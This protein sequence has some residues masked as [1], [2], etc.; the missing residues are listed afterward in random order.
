MLSTGTLKPFQ[1]DPLKGQSDAQTQLYNFLHLYFITV[2]GTTRLSSELFAI[3]Y[4]H[5]SVA[6]VLIQ[7]TVVFMCPK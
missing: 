7:I 4:L 5:L 1:V 3:N 6:K 2:F